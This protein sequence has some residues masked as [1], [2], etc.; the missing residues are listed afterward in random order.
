[1]TFTPEQQEILKRYF[2][3]AEGDVFAL[4][5]MPEVVKGTLFSRYSRT[6][7]DLRTLFLEDF[8][9]S[10]TIGVLFGKADDA[11]AVG[12]DVARAEEFYE[13]VLVGYGDDSVA[14]LGGAH[15][16][17]ENVSCLAT[18]SIEE[19]RLGLS[20]LEKSTRYVYFDRKDERGSYPYYKDPKIMASKHREVY[21]AA[22][23][24]LF[25]AYAKIVR[26]IQPIL[27]G[28]D[29]CDPKEAS[30]RASI[31]AKACDLARG[32]LPLA[33]LTNMG[34]F[35]N[36]R[37]FEYLLTHLL[38]D[39]LEE[40]RRIGAAMDRN[41]R[42][43]IGAF[44]KRATGERGDKY[45]EYLK[46]T[47]FGLSP[48]ANFVSEGEKV[49]AIKVELVGWDEDAV[50]RMIAA[51]IYERSG[52]PY[53]QAKEVVDQMGED[54][55]EEIMRQAG[56]HRE[57]RHHKPP[58]FFEEPYFCFDVTAD[59]GVYKDLQR[60]RILTRYKQ[61]FTPELGYVVP[62]EIV[63]AGFESVYREAMARAA[64]AYAAIKADFPYE[65]QYLVAH[66]SMNRFYMKMNLRALVHM[67]ELRS[68]SQGHPTYRKVAQMMAKA[69][70]EKLPLLGRHAFRFVDYN[71]YELERLHAFR[72]LETKAAAAGVDAFKEEPANMVAS[73]AAE[74][75]DMKRALGT[76][77]VAAVRKMNE[78][79]Y[80]P[81]ECVRLATLAQTA[82]RGGDGMA[83]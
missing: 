22:M 18:K 56:G 21:L 31:R 2:T 67:V 17:I 60:H 43:V 47:E 55:K 10:E 34:V 74:N 12:V 78:L 7:K 13:R 73:E 82:L 57:N 70:E 48:L 80:D 58:R 76:T 54:E 27:L 40:S 79:G 72:K 37:A 19:H 65:A 52:L 29:L 24:G 53:A 64:E 49:E 15:I 77:I 26:E 4:A 62:E 3:D 1:M 30:C 41:L 35:G 39:P 28:L 69:V 6:A 75:G 66:G 63:K 45:R 61:L 42:P 16:A 32:L 81:E 59:W 44:V 25:D 71:D 36:G 33:T 9:N 23:D 20:P 68:S 46:A 50:D 5:N 51:A 11:P 38:N 8:Y 14:E 83:R